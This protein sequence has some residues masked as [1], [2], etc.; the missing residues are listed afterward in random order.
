MWLVCW[1]PGT[2]TSSS[3]LMRIDHRC[4]TLVHIKVTGNFLNHRF[5]HRALSQTSSLGLGCSS[6][7]VVWASFHGDSYAHDS[8]R[9]GLLCFVSTS[10]DATTFQICLSEITPWLL[11]LW[12]WGNA[13]F[14]VF[15]KSAYGQSHPLGDGYTLRS[16]LYFLSF[17]E[18]MSLPHTPPA[19]V[20]HTNCRFSP[21]PLRNPHT[22]GSIAHFSISLRRAE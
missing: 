7:T 3:F 9:S 10:P 16:Q 22:V 2:K 14:T 20:S 11:W 15:Q 17:W 13:S 5:I 12:L 21:G 4:L 1:L 8:V 6:L 19:L 18:G